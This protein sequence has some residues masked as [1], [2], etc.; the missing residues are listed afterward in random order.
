MYACV[1]ACVRACVCVCV[2]V[3]II[4][5]RGRAG[6]LLRPFLLVAY[7]FFCVY[8]TVFLPQN[9]FFIMISYCFHENNPTLGKHSVTKFEVLNAGVHCTDGLNGNFCRRLYMFYMR[10]FFFCLV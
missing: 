1:R 2:C 9:C 10:R 7:V 3:L 5:C 4:V 8:F 6:G